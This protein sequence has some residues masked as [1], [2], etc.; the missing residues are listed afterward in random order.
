MNNSD[1][2]QVLNTNQRPI[3]IIGC[4]RSGTT[5]L[6]LLLDSHRHISCGPETS[7]LTDLKPILGH[8]W[9]HLKLYGFPK[10]Y[11]RQKIARFFETFQTEYAQKRGKRRWAEKTPQYT[12]HLDFI[13][14]L[15][16][17]CQLVH[18]IRDGRDVVVSYKD[19]WGYRAALRSILEWRSYIIAAQSFGKQ[20]GPDQYHE[21][22]YEDL[23][24]NPEST[25][26]QLLDYLDEP[27]DEQMLSYM[28]SAHDVQPTYAAHIEK[29]RQPDDLSSFY[30]SRIGIW[31]QELPMSLQVVFRL[32]SGH[33]LKALGYE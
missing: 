27:W 15:F 25:L 4:P 29:Q 23:V 5:L 19:R 32:W 26:R 11:W 21:L 1:K 16:P 17:N 28:L 7:F 3:F 10:A 13:M 20:V 18:I 12:P 22:R 24:T 31:Q 2:P 6:R 14:S 8:H 9:A 30:T 33:L